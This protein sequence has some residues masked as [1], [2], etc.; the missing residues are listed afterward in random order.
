MYVLIADLNE[1]AAGVSEQVASHD[2]AI[3]K[4]SEVRVNSQLPRVAECL[5]LLNLTA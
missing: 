5:D 1:D 4:V 3:P 2:K